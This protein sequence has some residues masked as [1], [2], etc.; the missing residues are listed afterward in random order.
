MS[1]SLYS[2]LRFVYRHL[3]LVVK[4]RLRGLKA[5]YVSKSYSQNIDHNDCND[6]TWGQFCS[7][8]LMFSSYK[9]IYIQESPIDWDIDLFQRPQHISLAMGRAGFLVI[10]L[11]TNSTDHLQGL[12][13]VAENVWVAPYMK[14]IDSIKGAVRSVYSTSSIRTPIEL[15]GLAKINTLVY[16]YIDHI[17]P[18]ISGEDRINLLIKNKE[19][20]LSGKTHYVIASSKALINEFLDSTIS[21]VDPENV[22]FIPNG[23]DIDHYL[24]YDYDRSNEFEGLSSLINFKKRFK[25]C[26]G[27]FGAMAP[28]LWYDLLNEIAKKRQDIGFV[29][30]GPDYAGGSK[31][32]E[33]LDNVLTL[34]SIPYPKLP[35]YASHFDLCCV[36]FKLGQIAKTTSPLKLYEYFAMGKPVIIT[37]DLLECAQYQECFVAKDAES[38]SACIDQALGLKNDKQFKDRCVQIARS[39]SW[40]EYAKLYEK[41]FFCR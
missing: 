26:V 20:A 41:H 2:L 24:K 18:E 7:S 30:I 32:L 33:K 25:G 10:Y 36:P 16:E 14:E 34:G 3:P 11:S 19:F 8:V 15:E 40:D 4:N 13:K 1:S 23:V 29:Y 17:D 5:W 21:K 28:W 12:R 37:P 27:Y 31:K 39:H 6:L 9:G 22:V 35:S 38:F